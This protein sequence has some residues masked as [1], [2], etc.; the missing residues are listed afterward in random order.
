MPDSI[1]HTHSPDKG[2]ELPDRKTPHKGENYAKLQQSIRDLYPDGLNDRE[3]DDATRNLIGFG[4][5]LL[6][7]KCRQAQT[8]EHE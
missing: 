1:P 4:K 8:P 3:A 5:L 2:R 6:E 7:I